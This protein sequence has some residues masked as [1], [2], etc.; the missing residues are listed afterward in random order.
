MLTVSSQS[1]SGESTKLIS[2]AETKTES[3]NLKNEKRV[4]KRK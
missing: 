1:V 4:E 2:L 3:L